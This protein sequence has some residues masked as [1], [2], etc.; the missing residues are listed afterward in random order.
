[1]TEPDTEVQSATQDTTPSITEEG[2]NG[3]EDRGSQKAQ[4]G[5]SSH[6]ENKDESTK[7][8][9]EK[10]DVDS[11]NNDEENDD[12]EDED[13]DDDE[14]DSAQPIEPLAT[15]RSRRS[16]AGNRMSNLI[17]EEE[18]DFYKNLY[19]GFHEE[20]DDG[21]FDSENEA[22][23]DEVE[24]DYDV[25][26][27]FSIDETDEIAP[28]HQAVEDEPKKKKSTYR[29]PKP[30]AQHVSISGATSSGT[31]VQNK[32]PK[33]SG[34]SA[35]S[36][37]QSP[38]K[39]R[40]ERSFRDSTRKKTAETIKNIET[41][42]KRRKFRNVEPHKKLTQEELLEEAKKTEEENLKS[43]EIYQRL[44]SE[45]LKKIK[46]I[47]KNIPAPY[48]SYYSSVFTNPETKERYSRN[49][50]TFV[51]CDPQTKPVKA[52]TSNGRGVRTRS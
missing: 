34:P 9:E 38:S 3:N 36:T 7:H 10:M 8:D 48:V 22:D 41:G 15:T 29:E 46:L 11:E 51:G 45:K 35:I 4:N 16:N 14:E 31:A 26:S 52:N 40:P 32:T 23:E 27:D 12:E 44:E 18:D 28:E 47:K 50:C 49:L 6:D 1:M 19:G 37:P 33:P 13:E 42:K 43:L 17:Q 2:A 20:E 39:H 24:E 30:R 5:T 21:D 25:D